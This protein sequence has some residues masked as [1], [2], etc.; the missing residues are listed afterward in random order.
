MAIKVFGNKVVFPDNTEQTTAAEN[1]W[2][3]NGSSAE[4]D[5][6]GSATTE[7]SV[8]NNG[9]YAKVIQKNDGQSYFKGDGATFFGTESDLPVNIFVGGTNQLAVAKDSVYSF[10]PVTA[11]SFI[12]DGSQLT[13]L[14]TS[15]NS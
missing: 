7:V 14:P 15:R 5:G 13:G 9:K 6:D 3:D 4:F 10:Q 2:K 1:I 11:P 12:G 8:E